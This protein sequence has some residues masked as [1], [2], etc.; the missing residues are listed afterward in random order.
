MVQEG[1]LEIQ[2]AREQLLL[3]VEGLRDQIAELEELARRTRD[4]GLGDLVPY[5]S[6]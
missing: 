6:S 3:Q 2:A 1:L 4:A 5:A